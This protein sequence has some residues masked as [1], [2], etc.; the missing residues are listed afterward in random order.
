MWKKKG[1]V[2]D[3]NNHRYI[4]MKDWL[5]KLCEAL[6]VDQMKTEIISGGTIYQIGGIPGHR[7]EEHL[8]VVKS[9]IQMSLS[10][11][12]GCLVQLADFE[13]F[14][15]SENLRGLMGSL[16]ESKVND[17]AYRIWYKLNEKAVISV[18]SP[19]GISEKGE[20]G[21][22]CPQ[23]GFGGALAS[24]LDLA[25]GCKAYFQGS[26]DE[27]SYGRGRSNPELYQDDLL[28]VAASTESAGA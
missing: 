18:Q 21:R 22:I 19:A 20:A 27:L 24:G 5:P 6:T 13:K 8:V 1:S 16:A 15:D 28:R 14:F 4:H 25:L 11:K 9:L 10:R 2:S 7:R 23:G 12:T 3:L 17:K 26:Q